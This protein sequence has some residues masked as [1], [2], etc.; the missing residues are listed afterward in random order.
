MN[1]HKLSTDKLVAIGCHGLCLVAK[2]CSGMSTAGVQNPRFFWAP[3]MWQ[4]QPYTAYHSPNDG[5]EYVG[6]SAHEILCCGVDCCSGLR[7][8]RA[9][10]IVGI[11]PQRHLQGAV[12]GQVLHLLDLH[13]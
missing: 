6:L 1:F 9:L 13:A 11:D 12:P 3:K 10:A 7:L 4:R 2:S 5:Q 8:L